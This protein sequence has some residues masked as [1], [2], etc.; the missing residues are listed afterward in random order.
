MA[1]EGGV[2][3]EAVGFFADIGIFRVVLP[4]L[5]V[6]TMVFAILE[7]TKVLGTEKIGGE[8]VPRKNINS[9][10]AFVIAFLVVGSGQLVSII[11]QTVSQM[12]VLLALVVCFMILVGSFSKEDEGYFA[13]DSWYKQ[14]FTVIMF[15]GIMLIT[16]GSIDIQGKNILLIGW[17]WLVDNITTT[18]VASVLL[19]GFLIG[20]MVIITMPTKKGSKGGDE[21]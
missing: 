7:K 19:I 6:F 21:E 8:D 18:A 3:G 20:M 10:V 17:E 9:I 11:N 13:K 16:M 4:F 2:L 15:V 5:L 12:V 14:A 1:T